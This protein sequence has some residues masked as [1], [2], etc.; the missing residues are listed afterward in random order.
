MA[1]FPA[2]AFQTRTAFG[3]GADV[4]PSVDVRA[5]RCRWLKAASRPDQQRETAPVTEHRRELGGL[6]SSE[7]DPVLA[8]S[9]VSGRLRR[10][11]RQA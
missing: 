2:L 6:S 11:T 9:A 3:T 7:A 10:R 5:L 8:G 4:A 1:A